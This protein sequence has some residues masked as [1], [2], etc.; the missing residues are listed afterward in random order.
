[1]FAFSSWSERLRSWSQPQHTRNAF[2]TTYCKLVDDQFGEFGRIF[3]FLEWKIPFSTLQAVVAEHDFASR[4]GRAPGEE[5]SFSHRRKGQPGDWRNHF[6]S[7]TGLAFEESFPR[8]LIDLGYEQSEDWWQALNAP[9]EQPPP[10]QH[11]RNQWLHVLEEYVTELTVVRNAAAER[12]HAIHSLTKEAG[13]KDIEL[14]SLRLAAAER[15][16]G[17]EQLTSVAASAESTAAERLRLI[18]SLS[19]RIGELEATASARLALIESLSAKL[20]TQHEAAAERSRII[21]SL[22]AARIALEQ[23]WS[24]KLGF[25]PLR[26]L[27]GLFKDGSR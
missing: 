16:R 20:Q 27:F 9:L 24:Y 17:I 8:L 10:E 14:E 2:V 1:M 25:A 22:H 4:T 7:E 5:N 11:E 18:E 3:D 26:R 13:N 12:L 19:A 23:S 15:L 6:D 21:E